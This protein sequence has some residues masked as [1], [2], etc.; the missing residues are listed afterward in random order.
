MKLILLHI[1]FIFCLNANEVVLS[2]LLGKLESK[3]NLHVGDRLETDK[4]YKTAK[5]SKLQLLI[6]ATAV[7]TA[8]QKSK[9][10]L[11]YAD[12][13]TCKID[14]K[15]GTYKIFNLTSADKNIKIELHTPQTV[16][17]IQNSI[18]LIKVSDK[19]LKLASAKNSLNFYFDGKEITLN[20]DKMVIIT[21]NSLR[22]QDINY[23]DFEDVYIKTEK[24]ALKSN[25]KNIPDGDPADLDN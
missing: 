8:S 24:R 5:N 6:N 14:I 23:D 4:I 9:F 16:I 2:A 3:Q 25:I 17:V 20:D 21:N 13:F 11:I 1:L 12:A 22:K 10:S 15:S 18:S 7:I 19:I